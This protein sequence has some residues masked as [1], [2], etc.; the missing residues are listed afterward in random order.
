MIY[1]IIKKMH[2]A[3]ACVGFL[4]WLSAAGTSDLAKEL[5]QTNPQSVNS[6]IVIGALFMIPTVLFLILDY[7]KVNYVNVNN[8]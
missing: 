7:I 3:S 1:R 2:I 4:L 5:G 6:H 8:R